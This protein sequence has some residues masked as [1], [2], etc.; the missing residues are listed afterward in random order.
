M[1]KKPWIVL[2][3]DSDARREEIS[4]H[5]MEEIS[6]RYQLFRFDPK[7]TKLPSASISP[8]AKGGKARTKGPGPQKAPRKAQP[9]IASKADDLGPGPYEDR[10]AALFSTPQFSEIALFATDRDLSRSTQLPGLSEAAVSKAAALLGVPVCVYSA[11]ADD[12]VLQRQRSGGD[13]RIVLD[14]SNLKRMAHRIYVLATG[15]EALRRDLDSIVSSKTKNP[16]GPA[17]LLAM[18]LSK[19]DAAPHIALYVSGDQ[20]MIAEVM[21]ASPADSIDAV[22]RK[23]INT[24]LGTWLC[25]SVLRFPGVLLDEISA[26]SF[27]NVSP[28]RFSPEIRA[29][30]ASALYQGP[31]SDNAEPRWWRHIVADILNDAK[32]PDGRSYVLKRLNK[33]LPPC[34][35][36]VDQKAP[37]GFICAVTLKPVCK[38]HSVGQVGWLPRGADLTRVTREVFEELSPWIGVS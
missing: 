12:S 25:D 5:L 8:D 22:Q 32:V 9:A 37:A 24:A 2:F 33:S 17:M 36:S 18:A 23:R 20:R 29:L 3:E 27:L 21:P 1:T 11:G 31:F 14:S 7:T 34:A 16:N 28:S 4:S 6:S 30:F 26:A 15:F 19:P 38:A 10:I 35:C 13:G